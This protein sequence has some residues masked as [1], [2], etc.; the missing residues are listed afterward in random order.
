M[1]GSKNKQ[2]EDEQIPMD[3]N[4]NAYNMEEEDRE[5]NQ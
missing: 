3:D 2:P 1:E 4:Q 5:E